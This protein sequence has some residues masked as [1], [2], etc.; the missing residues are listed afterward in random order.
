ML[1]KT[2]RESIINK[3]SHICDK[4]E[5]DKMSVN[6]QKLRGKMIEKGFTQEKLSNKLG[7][8]KSTLNRKLKA[9][10]SSLLINEVHLI[11]KE[12]ELSEQE[13]T[14]IFFDQVSQ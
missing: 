8:N 2:H 10:G 14:D 9:G 7:I 1:T 6:I 12:L 4:L 5:G 11:A 3:K 13:C